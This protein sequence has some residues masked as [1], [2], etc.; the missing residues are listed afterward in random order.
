ME[1]N[2]IESSTSKLLVGQKRSR[3]TEKKPAANKRARK[4]A[5]SK[6]NSQEA[7][8]EDEEEDEWSSETE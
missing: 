8:D 6:D 5:P 3:A 7:E 4:V 2:F 1:L